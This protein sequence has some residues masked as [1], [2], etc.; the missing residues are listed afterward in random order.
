MLANEFEI[1]KLKRFYR[2]LDVPLDASARII[3]LSYRLHLKRWHPDLYRSGTPAHA[4]ATQM[5]EL[6]N[7]A[8]SA[9]ADA[10]L[11]YYVGS[12]SEQETDVQRKESP[13]DTSATVSERFIL[14][15]RKIEFALRL[16]CGM[17]F[18]IYICLE[19]SFFALDD[20]TVNLWVV[21][22]GGLA[23]VLTCGFAAARYGDR[24]WY[25]IFR[26]RWLWP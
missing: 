20:T 9:I 10:P 14:M 8:Y 16:V 4:E 25:W 24:F 22:P 12:I 1:A 5:A 15:T 13:E 23:I 11:R 21:V 19:L 6:L 7:A 17:L 26:R 3:K 18:G 2:T